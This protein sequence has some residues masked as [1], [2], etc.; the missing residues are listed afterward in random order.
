MYLPVNSYDEVDIRCI[1]DEGYDTEEDGRKK[2][3]IA[4]RRIAFKSLVAEILNRGSTL[5]SSSSDRSK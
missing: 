5:T 1:I 4:G 3:V 2:K